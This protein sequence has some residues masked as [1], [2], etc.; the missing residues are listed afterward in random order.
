MATET[1][2]TGWER[3]ARLSDD[4]EQVV[5]A[6]RANALLG[7]LNQPS[8]CD[9]GL[10]AIEILWDPMHIESRMLDGHG[11]YVSN[12]W[13]DG[14]DYAGLLYPNGEPGEFTDEGTLVHG[15][16]GVLVLTGDRVRH[17]A[18]SCVAGIYEANR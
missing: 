18:L 10:P 17:N 16:G 9:K 1:V 12:E 4:P 5:L 3:R 13:I 8:L 7:Q 15:D 6:L 2:E 14:N 11:V